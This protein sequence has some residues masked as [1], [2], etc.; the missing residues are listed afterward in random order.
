MEDYDWRED[1]MTRLEDI[2]LFV[3]R[4]RHIETDIRETAMW[5]GPV[6][7][8]GFCTRLAYCT[9]LHTPAE[10]REQVEEL[11]VALKA[12]TAAHASLMVW[13]M[14]ELLSPRTFRN[15]QLRKSRQLWK[16]C[17]EEKLSMKRAVGTEERCMKTESTDA[18]SYSTH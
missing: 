1:L 4:H 11:L 12:L 5:Y 13:E 15:L 16:L 9:E 8:L 14:A 6:P 2:A 17:K 18:D 10:W 3:H 7:Q